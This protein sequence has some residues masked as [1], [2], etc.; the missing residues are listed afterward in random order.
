MRPSKNVAAGRATAV[1][2]AGAGLLGASGVALSAAAAHKGGGE[3]TAI[4]ATMAILHAGS[5]LAITALV[6]LASSGAV[7]L[8]C[9]AALMV[10]G[11]ILFSGDLALAALAGLHPWPSAA[12]FGGGMLI[13]AWT[14]LAVTFASRALRGP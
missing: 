8:L 10:L 12:P 3:L 6:G 5:V 9:E 14:A 4:A 11:T 13:L 2:Q 1:L 7:W